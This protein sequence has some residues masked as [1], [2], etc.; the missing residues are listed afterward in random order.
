MENKKEL[1][2]V[3]K[4]IMPK[5]T[6]DSKVGNDTELSLPNDYAEEAQVISKSL[7]IGD[8]INISGI[9]ERNFSKDYYKV[10]PNETGILVITAEPL[11][12]FEIDLI[13]IDNDMKTRL[14]KIGGEYGKVTVLKCPVKRAYNFYI[15]VG[16]NG[17]IEEDVMP[18]NLQISYVKPNRE[19]I[20][21]ND[22]EW[23][24]Q[25]IYEGENI[26][27]FYDS[28]DDLDYYEIKFP[29]SGLVNFSLYP[30][31][32]ATD[33]IFYLNDRN[34]RP[35]DDVRIR[36]GEG[37]TI[38]YEVDG[39]E[40]YVLL[41][42]YMSGA[43]G[44]SYVLNCSYA[45]QGGSSQKSIFDYI[46]VLEKVEMEA[47]KYFGNTSASKVNQEAMSAIRYLAEMHKEGP[48]Y[49]GKALNVFEPSSW[50]DL[51]G[52]ALNQM[53]EG[54]VNL[55]SQK[56]PTLADELLWGGL[57]PMG[58]EIDFMHLIA[59]FEGYAMPKTIGNFARESYFG[60]AGDL[61]SEAGFLKYKLQK[62]GT[63]ESLSNAIQRAGLQG[64]ANLID[65]V[66]DI[67]AEV[68]AKTIYKRDKRTSECFKEYY[69][70]TKYIQRHKE[71]LELN[72]GVD[73]IESKIKEI[74]TGSITGNVLR[75]LAYDSKNL[76]YDKKDNPIEVFYH[77]AMG[78][79]FARYVKA[80]A[81]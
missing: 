17:V 19:E 51:W 72:N 64:K 57:D 50:S 37:K 69:E 21:I 25:R 12:D 16:F 32:D 28:R 40:Y 6:D 38:Q 53:N 47:E 71:F 24:A 18:Y 81:K 46:E 5:I 78:I 41:V 11:G 60:W 52:I 29:Q 36:S 43:R 74:M 59:T 39:G 4:V 73:G 76:P 22:E 80:N 2:R 55:L 7:G 30:N 42:E 15:S 49:Y 3:S 27:G 26:L 61:A 62:S 35:I 77:E 8:A 33:M 20:E 48:N 58:Q 56:Y 10:T 44:D 45:G 13:L 23:E 75:A 79:K 9:A 68:I 63:A 1:F 31:Y 14:C 70:G 54:F 65:M 66:T 34:N 67:D